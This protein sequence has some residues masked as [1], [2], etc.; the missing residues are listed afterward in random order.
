MNRPEPHLEDRMNAR[1]RRCASLVS[2]HALLRLIIGWW[3]SRS[4]GGCASQG[5]FAVRARWLSLLTSAFA[6]SLGAQVVHFDLGTPIPDGTATGIADVRTVHGVAPGRLISVDL[7]LSGIGEGMF[8]GDIFATLSHENGAG[9]VDAFSV[10]LNRPGKRAEDAEGY[11]DNGLH[12]RFTSDSSA[13]DIHQYRLFLNADHDMPVPGGPTGMWSP[14]GRRVD[15]GLVLDTDPRTA[16]LDA[17]NG[18]DAHEGRWTLF[19]ADLIPG[20]EARLDSWSLL[21]VPEPPD[22]AVYLAL[23]LVAWRLWVVGVAGRARLSKRTVD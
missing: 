8:N 7:A 18:I 14:D 17:F 20:G 5:R 4:R 19:A 9:Q 21:F 22:F 23:A 15:P 3:R 12:V 10:L 2:R 11:A 1:L 13:P 16:L 6:C